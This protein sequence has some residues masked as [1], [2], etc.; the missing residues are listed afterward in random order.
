MIEAFTLADIEHKLVIAGDADFKTEYSEQLKSKAAENP[1][2]ILTG[3]ITGEKLHEVYSHASLF[4]L[5]SYHEGL[6]ISLLEALSY[7]LKPLVSDIPANK[8]VPLGEEC[9]FKVGDVNDLKSKLLTSTVRP[10]VDELQQYVKLVRDKYNWK[11][12]AEETMDVYQKV[13]KI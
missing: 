12:I 11:H 7:G 4:A 9:F 5:P 6:P 3:Y 10:C 2:I 8:Q 1:N 13:Y